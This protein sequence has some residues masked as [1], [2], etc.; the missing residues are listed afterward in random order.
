LREFDGEWRETYIRAIPTDLL[1]SLKL[2]SP[3]P[4]LTTRLNSLKQL[5]V[6]SQRLETFHYVDRGQGTNFNFKTGE[7]MPALRDLSLRSY[8]WNHSA[9]EVKAHWDFSK[10]ESLEL[11]FVPVFNFLSSVDFSKLRG[12]RK[13]HCEDY[14]AHLPDQRRQATGA[15]YIL[16]G[17]HIHGMEELSITCHVLLFPLDAILAHA[18]TLQVLH[19]R[20]HVGFAEEDR[21][22]P[23]LWA[24]DL[25]ELANRLTRVHTLELDMDSKLCDPAEFIRSICS[26]R[27]LQCLT[28]HVQTVLHPLE[29]AQP[30]T[31]RDYAAAVRTF[32]LL[33]QG[34]ATVAAA[35]AA[36]S[37][38]NT[39]NAVAPWRRITINVGGW[40]RV[41]VRR[42]S[43]AWRRQNG[44]GVF[45][46]R[47]FVLERDVAGGLTVREEMCVESGAIPEAL[48]EDEDDYPDM[49][50]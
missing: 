35:A 33:L 38:G 27:S 39:K 11:L 37:A 6:Q 48:E 44:H 41:M 45:A 24:E 23:T 42:M 47:C 15:L 30:G 9:E 10:M 28:L 21:R 7:R 5:L 25:S 17:Q 16:I 43:T 2:S 29:A 22:C 50:E 34:K 12:L 31:D 1:V 4:P 46:E 18:A 26:F 3:A 14:S 36:A 19:F 32:N 13:L 40:K 49:T 8:D 20:D